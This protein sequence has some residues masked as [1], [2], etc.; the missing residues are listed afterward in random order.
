MAEHRPLLR[1]SWGRFPAGV[2][3]IFSIS[4]KASL[5]VCLPL[6]FLCGIT[7]QGTLCGKSVLTLIKLELTEHD[8]H[9][10]KL[11]RTQNDV[12]WS[13]SHV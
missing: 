1:G 12:H 3:S 11:V 8:T 5:Q 4:A 10:L 7:F 2:I 13:K 9:S 6:P